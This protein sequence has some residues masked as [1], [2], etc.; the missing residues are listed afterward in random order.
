MNIRAVI[1]IG[2]AGLILIGS[3]ATAR[4]ELKCYR[5]T[6]V[7]PNQYSSLA[8]NTAGQQVRVCSV[9]VRGGVGHADIV[10]SPDGLGTNSSAIFIAEPS[11]G[12]SGAA[13]STGR[14]DTF[15]TYGLAV[16]S[17]N[18][19]VIVHYDTQDR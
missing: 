6:V 2:L 12:T 7:R 17:S 1:G 8:S 3:P 16:E 9:E 11:N 18:V 4:A 14:I 13:Y 10:D 19:T 5:H 15:V